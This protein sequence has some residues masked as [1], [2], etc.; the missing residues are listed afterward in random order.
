MSTGE[1]AQVHPV[2][3]ALVFLSLLILLAG[4]AY[5]GLATGVA[6]YLS[7]VTSP[8]SSGGAIHSGPNGTSYS[9]YLGEN[10]TCAYRANLSTCPYRALF[11]TRPSEA[12]YQPF[13]G[14][15][16]ESPYGPTDP[17][18]RNETLFY[19]NATGPFN[20]SNPCG[21]PLELVS[22]SASGLDPD[23]SVCGALVQIP[24]IAHFSHLTERQLQDLVNANIQGS[25]VPYI[26]AKYVNVVELDM[27]LIA[28]VSSGG[29]G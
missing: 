17:A 9:G 2:R 15:G 29:T 26:G 27:D 16:N 4:L 3:P 6:P 21:I 23:V 18:L 25:G 24:R 12:D 7:D 14:A 8:G 13:S 28:L 10:I 20:S 22:D 5:P 19:I 11:W 1:H